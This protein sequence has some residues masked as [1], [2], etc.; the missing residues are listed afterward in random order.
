MYDSC[1]LGDRVPY[2]EGCE[3]LDHSFLK[4]CSIFKHTEGTNTSYQGTLIVAPATIAG[5][6]IFIQITCM[7]SAA[8][9][10]VPVPAGSDSAALSAS[11]TCCRACS[12]YVSTRSG[13]LANASA[14]CFIA[15]QAP[16]LQHWRS[17]SDYP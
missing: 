13:S 16:S 12:M 14:Q 8:S 6:T 1:P 7:A 15:R 3:L 17:E 9:W 11:M 2:S 5:A 4:P 10:R